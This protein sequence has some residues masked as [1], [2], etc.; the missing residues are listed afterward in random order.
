MDEKIEKMKNDYKNIPIP[1]EL[2]L[3]VERALKTGNRKKKHGYKWLVGSAAAA[4]IFTAGIN[5][6]SAMAKALADVPLIG[7][8]VKVLTF[9]EFKVEKEDRY[10]ANIKVPALQDLEN[11]ELAK[12]LNEKYL[13]ESKELYE[14]FMKDMEEMDKDELGGH[15]GVDGGYEIKTDN[16]QILS[17]GRY[18]VNTVASSSTTMSYDTIDKKK[19]ILLRLPMLFKDDSYVT[20]ISENIKEQMRAQMQEVNS[21][22]FYWVSGVPQ[23]EDTTPSW[24]FETIKKDQ[25]FYISTE[26]K[27]VISFDKYEVAPGSQGIVEFTIPTEVILNI[28]V[29]DEYIH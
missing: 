5:T 2:D 6:S 27:L 11:E 20:I 17:I 1:D 18:V 3:V 12:S 28:L 26:G 29:G 16:K 13:N 14:E 22:N 4:V 23:T 7:S 25:N 15:L 19:G 8:V 9:T 24:L 21:E 10:N